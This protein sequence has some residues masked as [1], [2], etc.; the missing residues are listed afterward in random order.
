MTKKSTN[1]DSRALFGAKFTEQFNKWKSQGEN[2]TEVSFGQ[3]LDP[4][5]SRVSVSKWC[6]GNNIPTPERLKQIRDIFGVP[7]DYFDTDN[8]TNE[9]KYHYSS[10]YMTDFGKKH[11]EFAKMIGLDLD[12]IRALSHVVD[13]DGL[14]PLYAPINEHMTSGEYDR[15]VNFA[16]SAH[17]E[18]VD[19]DLRFLQVDQDGKRVT[20][21]RGDLAFLKEVQ[22]QIVDFT[23]YLFYHRSKQ[24]EEE[25]KK[26]NQDRLEVTV[27]GKTVSGSVKDDYLKKYDAGNI[28]PMTFSSPEEFEKAWK[29]ASQKASGKTV[30]IKHKEVTEEFVREHDRFAQ[31]IYLFHDQPKPEWCSLYEPEEIKDEEPPRKATQEDIDRFFSAH[32]G[33]REVKLP[34]GGIGIVKEGK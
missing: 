26:F 7:D 17:M 24:M 18:D 25:T 32:K 16:D 5:A 9:Q 29:E 1:R 33:E 23:E 27:D 3:L 20:F 12:L 34:G 11:I 10:V 30:C 21:S 22:D 4:P 31:Y 14:F 6:S 15:K 19:E 13:F 2:R 28:E 8:M